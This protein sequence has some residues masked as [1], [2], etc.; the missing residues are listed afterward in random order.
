MFY[1]RGPGRQWS[2]KGQKNKKSLPGRE[3][4]NSSLKR[5]AGAAEARNESSV[6]GVSPFTQ[7][8]EP[9][10]PQPGARPQSRGC[11]GVS[12]GL[13]PGRPVS[14]GPREGELLDG[15]MEVGSSPRCA[16]CLTWG[17]G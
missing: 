6:I 13:A 5:E 15:W 14:H 7:R 4:F 2:W 11:L 8:W 3:S 9:R 1:P 17:L 16:T 10:T 12:L